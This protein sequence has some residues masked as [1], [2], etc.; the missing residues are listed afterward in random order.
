MVQ[1]TSDSIFKN[2]KKK[3]RKRNIIPISKVIL[4]HLLV[5]GWAYANNPPPT[6]IHTQQQGAMEAIAT[7]QTV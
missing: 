2:K 3:R 1:W 4:T 6:H 5:S 7:R